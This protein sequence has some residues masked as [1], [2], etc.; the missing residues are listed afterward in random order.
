[1]EAAASLRAMRSRIGIA[2]SESSEEDSSLETIAS[3]TPALA[4][5]TRTRQS[6]SLIEVVSVANECVKI[7]GRQEHLVGE[8]PVGAVQ[9]GAVG[10]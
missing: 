8:S 6:I 3:A 7:G 1:M 9:G 4:S 2:S 10:T 5:L